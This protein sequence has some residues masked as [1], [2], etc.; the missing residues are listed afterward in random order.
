M[1]M[2]VKFLSENLNSGVYHPHLIST[3]TYE[4]TI[5]PRV[6]S[7]DIEYVCFDIS[8]LIF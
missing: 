1:F 7:S 3:Y 2:Y 6:C 8:C 5:T 4:V